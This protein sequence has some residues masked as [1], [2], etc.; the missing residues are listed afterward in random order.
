MQAIEKRSYDVAAEAFHANEAPG[1]TVRKPTLD[2]MAQRLSEWWPSVAQQLNG[3]G[4]AGLRIQIEVHAQKRSENLVHS[5]YC[6][7]RITLM[8]KIT[9]VAV[10]G[11]RYEVEAKCGASLM[12]AARSN[13][14]P[15][16][17]ADCGGACVCATC[18]VVVEKDW[19]SV[20]GAARGI[21]LELL[22]LYGCDAATRLS[23]Q[24]DATNAMDGL[25]LKLPESQG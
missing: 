11:A 8:P 20:V 13:G 10:G 6:R 12:E 17:D 23:C 2:E 21:E 14:V 4:A 9:F 25:I 3:P 18:R 15:G 7:K 22:E 24:V 1:A 19:I 5:E 16:I